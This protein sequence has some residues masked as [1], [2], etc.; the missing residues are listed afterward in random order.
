[1]FVNLPET[2]CFYF[3][4]LQLFSGYSLVESVVVKNCL[5]Q[6]P[7][8]YSIATL[9]CINNKQTTKILDS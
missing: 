2:V 9:P 3:Q 8:S 5:Y 1:M 6:C 7:W 4:G